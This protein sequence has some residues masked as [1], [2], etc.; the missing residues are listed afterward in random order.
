MRYKLS[1]E[2]AV[3]RPTYRYGPGVPRHEIPAHDTAAIERA[4][5]ERFR[6][7]TPPDWRLRLLSDPPDAR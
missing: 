7:P 4:V 5:R 3:D 6:G 1:A 2:D